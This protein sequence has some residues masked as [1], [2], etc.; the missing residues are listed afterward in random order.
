MKNT[1]TNR[2]RIEDQKHYKKIGRLSLAIAKAIRRK[3][4]DIYI[5]E[6]H[7]KHIE[8]N[9]SK[10]LNSIG[11]DA[12]TFVCLVVENFNQ[13]RI[14]KNES[15]LLVIYNGKPKVTAIELNYVLKTKFYEVKTATIMSKKRLKSKVILWEK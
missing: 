14:G 7:I 1:P 2:P 6:N 13:I 9:H 10:E 15:L 5:D 11:F 8:I 12:E 4:A 3:S